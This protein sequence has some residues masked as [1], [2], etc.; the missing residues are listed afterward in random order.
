MLLWEPLGK[1]WLAWPSVFTAVLRMTI[2]SPQHP[3]HVSMVL[4]NVHNTMSV[5]VRFVFF[6]D[7]S[8]PIEHT[9]R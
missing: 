4:L 5:E 2:P 3:A 8:F 9:E 6:V 7:Y 1:L